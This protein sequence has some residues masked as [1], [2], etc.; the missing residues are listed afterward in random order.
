MNQFKR[1]NFKTFLILAAAIL[2][3]AP[4]FNSVLFAQANN[5]NVS[6]SEILYSTS[7]NTNDVNTLSKVKPEDVKFSAEKNDLL[8]QLETAR[9]S[10]NMMLKSAVEEKLNRLN[11][12]S[13]VALNNDPNVIGGFAGNIPV[14]SESDFNTTQIISGGFWSTATQ[15]H[16]TSFPNPGR[17]WVATTQYVNG[18]TD[19]CKIYVS[20]NGGVSW[21]Y[22]YL[23]YF[24]SNMDFRPGELDIELAYDGTAVWIYGV[25]GYTDLTTTRK[26]S[27]LFRINT[28]T[29][30]YNGYILSFPGSS[31][32]T[33][34]Y[35]NPRITSDNSNYTTATYIYLTCSFDS[36]YSGTLHHNRQK[37]AHL[38]S[39]FAG[40]NTIDY[41]QPAFGGFYWNTSNVAAGSYLWTDI[42]YYRT[43]TN[44]NRIISIYSCPGSSNNNF[45]SAYSDDYGITITG[46]SSITETNVNY[47]ARMV[48]NGGASN[49]NGMIAYIRQFTGTDWD[50]YYRATTNGGTS[51]TNG[52]IDASGN[53]ARNVDVIA[54]RGA[55]NVFKVGYTQD[56]TT[57]V[58]GYYTGGTPGTWNSPN[59][60]A[61]SPAGVDTVFAKV[62]AGYKN[63][64]G[65]DCFAVYST[66]SGTNIYASRLCQGTVGINGNNN[67]IPVSYSLEQ[68]YP[69]PFN[70][71]TT[72][73]FSIPAGS[74]V[75]LVVY[76]AA[77]REVTELVNGELSAGNYDYSF[78]ALNL[79]SGVYFYKL[80]AGDFTAVKK[81]LLVK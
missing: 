52:Y 50:P 59:P 14:G 19:T 18:A 30:V 68:N 31:T 77:G 11:G 20:D 24:G 63:G 38:T 16:P 34:Q 22:A 49:Y 42:A 55:A 39:P 61:I 1:F 12:T 43:S 26:Q 56:S 13:P 69:N 57:G 66:G 74:F 23:F 29:N 2:T 73:K 65:D 45:Y 27:I 54:L 3:A 15:T 5:K 72:I 46:N 80:T 41:T 17:M 51:W 35:Y 53:R 33:N 6:P 75:K 40:S 81:M 28:T 44:T 8:N 10:N 36:T 60:M 4:V 9:I 58:Y 78:N 32:A 48:F 76:D 71:A 62:V 37:Y 70:P 79:S 64:G 7:S 67:E 21:S 25:A 47:G